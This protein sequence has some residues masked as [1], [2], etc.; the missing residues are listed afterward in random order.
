VKNLI[1]ARYF[2]K[3]YPAVFLSSLISK[4]IQVHPIPPPFPLMGAG[5]PLY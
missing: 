2:L 4:Q 1:M 5:R 3:I